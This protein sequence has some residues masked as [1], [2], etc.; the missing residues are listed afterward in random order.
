MGSGSETW[1]I[2]SPTAAIVDDNPIL[3]DS[4]YVLTHLYTIILKGM[5]A[6]GIKEP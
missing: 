6:V 4:T 5:S 1:V 3:K 2:G